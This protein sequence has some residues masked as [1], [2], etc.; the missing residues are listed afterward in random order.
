[1][2]SLIPP[3]RLLAVVILGCAAFAQAAAAQSLKDKT[4]KIVVPFPPG[5]TADV[6]ARLVTQH[7]GQASGQKTLVENRPGAGTII[8]TDQVARSAP[9][10]SNVLIMSNSFVIN[11]VVRA[12]L[13]YDPWSFEPVCMLV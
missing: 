12:Q 1:M 8:G 6:I 2:R 3:L 5:G 4:L 9:D 7:A 13:P 11:A 10:G